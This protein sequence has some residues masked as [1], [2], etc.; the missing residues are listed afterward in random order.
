MRDGTNFADVHN[1][2]ACTTLVPPIPFVRCW[3]EF[4]AH[5]VLCVVDTSNKNTQAA[6]K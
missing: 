3:G 1:V 6:T 2:G 5:K 4:I